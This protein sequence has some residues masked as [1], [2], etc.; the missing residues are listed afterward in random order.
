M[1]ILV[2]FSGSFKTTSSGPCPKH[3][4]FGFRGLGHGICGIGST[5]GGSYTDVVQHWAADGRDA[6]WHWEADR[7]PHVSAQAEGTG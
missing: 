2:W 5:P 7:G 1:S 3:N 6:P 4:E